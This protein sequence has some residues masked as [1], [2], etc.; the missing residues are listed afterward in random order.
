MQAYTVARQISPSHQRYR[1]PLIGHL[2][3][4]SSPTAFVG[5]LHLD[6]AST[7]T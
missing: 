1:D 7:T 5:F 3:A 4:Q 6:I 2:R